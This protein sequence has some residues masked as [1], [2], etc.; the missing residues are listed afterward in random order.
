MRSIALGFSLVLALGLSAWAQNARG[1]IGRWTVLHCGALLAIPGEAP[2]RNA[3]V[4]VKRGRITAV[5][6]GLVDPASLP[7][8]SDAQI[9]LIDLSQQFVLP[10]LIDAHVH[11][12]SEY[13]ADV[14]LRT[15]QQSDAD[16]ALQAVQYAKR[17]LDAGFTT[18]RDLGS[19][20]DAA[21]A[22]RDAIASEI[23]PGPRMLVAGETI[24]PTGGHGDDTLGYREDLFAV[25]GIMQGVADG[26][27]ACRKAVRAQVKRGADV[28]KLTATG[29]VLSVTAAG[30][31]QQFFDD[32]LQ[33]VVDTAHL[34]KRKVAAHAHGTRGINA[35]LRAGVDSIEHGTFLDDESIKLFLQTGAYL[36]PT[37]L[38][39]ETVTE[40]A[41]ITGYYPEEVA[42]KARLVG[43]SLRAAFA[44]AQKQGVK[45]AFGSDSSVSRHGENAREFKYM[46]EAGMSEMD[47]LIA[48]TRTGAD[49]C[50]VADRLGTIEVGK[51]ADL[52]VL[53]ANP[54]EDIS[55]VRK[56]KRVLKNGKLVNL[57]QDEGLTDYFELYC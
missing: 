34:L 13:S 26:P 43:P 9:E 10:G 35:A 4:V 55:N 30:T 25:P 27:D 31:E 3:T 44:R 39:G 16:R 37:L 29:G 52:L 15:L 12:S 51:L 46:V 36:V 14:R 1:P 20:G 32:E 54:L 40:R 19:S 49:L 53:S 24:T 5:L 11:M 48:A 42:E 45:I 7:G 38:A 33:A 2:L 57:E 8:A 41:R 6:A 22:L 21:F 23:V 18:V 47:A 28:I 17:T 56:V 50:E